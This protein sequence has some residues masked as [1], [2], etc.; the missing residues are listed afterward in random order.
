M[1]SCVL[2]FLS[3]VI[4]INI[5][6]GELV[7]A[8]VGYVILGEEAGTSVALVLSDTRTALKQSKR[9]VSSVEIA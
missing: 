5:M 4:N 1:C 7:H 9:T 3:L 8:D 6:S 2:F